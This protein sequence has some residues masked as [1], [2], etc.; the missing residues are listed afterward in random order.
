MKIV[1][2]SAFHGNFDALEALPETYNELWVLGDLVN[3]GPEPAAVVDF[4]KANGSI[5]VRGNHDH[6]IGYDEDPFLYRMARSTI[7]RGEVSRWARTTWRV[8]QRPLPE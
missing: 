1:I 4:V 8:S 5:L 7:E 3:Y 6:S 2:I